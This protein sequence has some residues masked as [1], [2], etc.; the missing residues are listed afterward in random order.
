[1][2]F[3]DMMGKMQL[4]HPILKTSTGS[5]CGGSQYSASRPVASVCAV[6]LGLALGLGSV[7]SSAAE[8]KKCQ[9]ADGNWHY[10]SFADTACANS[11]VAELDE[12]GTTTGIDKP[13]PSAEELEKEEQLAAAAAQA[14]LD[15]KAQRKLDLE[16]VRIYGSEQTIISTRDRK[17]ASIDNNIEVTRQIKEGTLKDIEKLTQMKKTKKTNRLLAEREEAVKSYNRVIRHNLTEREKL[18]E[19]YIAILSQF[20][21]A[22]GRIYGKE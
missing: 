7:G 3:T 5:K 22:Y 14:E 17:L 16:V 4:N 1:M 12:T 15:R 6:V 20:R 21:E 13:P 19:K 2:Y 9:D 11:D 10:G 18:S 8:I